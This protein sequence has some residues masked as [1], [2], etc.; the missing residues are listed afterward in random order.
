M[1]KFH[2]SYFP[3]SF[4]RHSKHSTALF[5][6]TDIDFCVEVWRQLIFDLKFDFPFSQELREGKIDQSRYRDEKG[7]VASD[8][9]QITQTK[10]QEHKNHLELAIRECRRQQ[11][12]DRHEMEA[13]LLREVR[14]T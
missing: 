6:S 9:H 8:Q 11:I 13:K 7:K 10:I 12:L 3:L 4:G 2:C 14:P 5:N 1:M